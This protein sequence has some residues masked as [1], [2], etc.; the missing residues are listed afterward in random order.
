M[1]ISAIM[2]EEMEEKIAI[3]AGTAGERP[4]PAGVPYTLSLNQ[5]NV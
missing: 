1:P 4:R 3:A 2:P 5:N